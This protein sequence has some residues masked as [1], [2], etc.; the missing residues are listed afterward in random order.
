M[1]LKQRPFERSQNRIVASSPALMSTRGHALEVPRSAALSAVLEMDASVS[2][3]RMTGTNGIRPATVP[4]RAGSQASTLVIRAMALG[5]VRL[6]DWWR[7]VR[8]EV[9]AGALLGAP[10]ASERQRAF[11]NALGFDT[12]PAD[13][14]ERTLD[15]VLAQDPHHSREGTLFVHGYNTNFVEGL[16]RGAQLQHDMERHGVSVFF[17]WPSQARALDYIADQENALYSRD[18]MAVTL[19]HT[20]V[21]ARDKRAAAQF[22]ARWQMC[23]RGWGVGKFCEEERGINKGV[24]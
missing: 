9:V 12:D 21:P 19:N 3:Y 20:I 2:Q 7:V 17:S 16:Y 10:I 18:A 4:A 15:A 14:V 13:V 1:V 23:W 22:F 11:L 8:R 24:F 6:R 5:E